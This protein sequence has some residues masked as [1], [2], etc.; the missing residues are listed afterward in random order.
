[1]SARFAHLAGIGGTF[2]A[3]NFEANVSRTLD[4]Y[5]V[6]C[7]SGGTA[8]DTFQ[9]LI[10]ALA[11]TDNRVVHTGYRGFTIDNAGVPAARGIV[12][13][14]VADGGVYGVTA[15]DHGVA[16]CFSPEASATEPTSAFPAVEDLAFDTTMTL[17]LKWHDASR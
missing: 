17:A 8:E 9:Q 7:P 4:F 16:V 6:H 12:H 13:N 15:F 14:I 11:D 2:S 10:Q 1:M 3:L 5:F